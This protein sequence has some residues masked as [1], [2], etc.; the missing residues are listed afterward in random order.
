M[1]EGSNKEDGD[2][3][4]KTKSRQNGRWNWDSTF[5]YRRRY[6]TI[7]EQVIREVKKDRRAQK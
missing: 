6:E 2:N 7:L 1:I 4:H 3:I 5:S